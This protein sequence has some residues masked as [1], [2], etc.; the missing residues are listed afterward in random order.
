MADLSDADFAIASIYLH[1]VFDREIPDDLKRNVLSGSFREMVG[2]DAR[3]E[4]MISAS[5]DFDMDFGMST[6]SGDLEVSEFQEV[7]AQVAR[8]AMAEKLEKA[9]PSNPSL[10]SFFAYPSS[11]AATSPDGEHVEANFMVAAIA[12]SA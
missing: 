11:F 7:A 4:R 12:M 3:L 1:V 10:Y 8:Q 5:G 2:S 9:N 6:A